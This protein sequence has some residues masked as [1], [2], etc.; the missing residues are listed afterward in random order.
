MYCERGETNGTVTPLATIKPMAAPLMTIEQ[1][2]QALGI[3]RSTLWRRLRSGN[4][5]SVRRGGRR[6]VQLPAGRKGPRVNVTGE[7]P[8]FTEDHPIFRLVGA[9]RGGG[10]PGARDKHAILDE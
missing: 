6:L 9:G 5:Q 1:A 8:P 10:R 7:I 3:S 4:I 2:T